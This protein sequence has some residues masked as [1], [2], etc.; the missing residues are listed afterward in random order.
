[1]PEVICQSVNISEG[2]MAVST[3]VPLNAEEPVQ[4]QF[5]LPNHREPFLAESKICWLKA[6]QFGVRFVSLPLER[7]SELQEWLSRKLEETLPESIACQ[8]QKAE[9]SSLKTSAIENRME[10]LDILSS[11]PVI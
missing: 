4:V 1:M 11:E 9:N 3:S 2:G 5:T 8:F 7:K 6:G 10:R